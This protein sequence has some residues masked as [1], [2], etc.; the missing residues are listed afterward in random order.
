MTISQ[1]YDLAF[2]VAEHLVRNYGTRAGQVLEMVDQDTVKG[3]RSGLYK[4]YRRLYEGAAATTGYPYLEAEVRYA[5]NHEYAVS[6]A[7]VLAR[8]TRLA[9]LNSTA[10]RL[11]L[12]RVVEIMAEPS[13]NSKSES[14]STYITYVEN[15]SSP[16]S[17]KRLTGQGMPGLVA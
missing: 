4:H 3:S 11:C 16:C 17:Q 6:P 1:K 9:F 2:D 15:S 14:L 13:R 10:A 7:D 8:R 5:V 12:P